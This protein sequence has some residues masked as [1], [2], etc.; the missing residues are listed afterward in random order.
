MRPPLVAI[1]VLALI[2]SAAGLA[3]GANQSVTASGTSFSPANV[4]V[5]QG[6]KVTW[7]NGGGTHNVKFDAIAVDLPADPSSNWG[8]TVE[9]TFTEAPATYSY[10]CEFHGLSMSG[11]VTVQA[12]PPPPPTNPPPTNPP[13][14]NPPPGGGEPGNPPP[15]GGGS[16]DLDPFKVKLSAGDRTPLAGKRFG[17]SG[18]VTPARDGRKLQ[19]QRRLANR[20]WK[21][22][23]T[24]TLKDAGS[25]KSKFSLRLKL[26]ADA[27]LRARVGGDD[28]RATGLSRG[29]EI[30][31]HR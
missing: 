24:V 28:E 14:T 17:L 4:T 27:V 5:T 25:A 12:P 19:I 18:T 1:V 8:G 10:H 26:G 6:E 11:T 13:P 23:A 31:V 29:L 15:G 21:T 9:H 3:R 20:K 2:L 7:T 22:I 30:D 16:D